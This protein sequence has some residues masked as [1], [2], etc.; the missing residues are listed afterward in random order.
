MR[1][2]FCHLKLENVLAILASNNEK[3]KQTGHGLKG[4]EM[5]TPR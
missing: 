5:K 2:I 1:N 4:L 3:K